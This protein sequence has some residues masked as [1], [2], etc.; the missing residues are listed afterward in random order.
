MFKDMLFYHELMVLEIVSDLLW[1]DWVCGKFKLVLFVVI[2][3]VN[4]VH[5]GRIDNKQSF[6]CLK[7]CVFVINYMYIVYKSH[8]ITRRF[9]DK[10]G[11]SW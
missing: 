1:Y 3:I 10:H 4:A 6:P 2:M 5:L 9:V 7:V 8:G 11:R